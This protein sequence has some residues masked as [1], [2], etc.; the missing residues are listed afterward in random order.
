MLNDGQHFLPPS[1]WRGP[2]LISVTFPLRFVDDEYGCGQKSRFL[3]RHGLVHTRVLAQEIKVPFPGSSAYFCSCEGSRA[4]T[5]PVPNPRTHQSPVWN[6][7]WTIAANFDSWCSRIPTFFVGEGVLWRCDPGFFSSECFDATQMV[8][9]LSND[10][11]PWVPLLR[12]PCARA[13]ER[14]LFERVNLL[15][16]LESLELLESLQ[17]VEQHMRVWP[18]LTYL[19][20]HFQA[21]QISLLLTYLSPTLIFFI[22]RPALIYLKSLSQPA[23]AR[24]T[25]RKTGM[26]WQCRVDDG[27]FLG[28]GPP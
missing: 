25:E 7:F 22:W 15:V 3:L 13:Q 24:K 27:R 5:K 11:C 16:I 14:G 1:L 19:W 18:F 8:A 2:P 21:F 4:R 20:T 6:A 17:S 28:G 26:I 9:Q 23:S 10:I 12:C